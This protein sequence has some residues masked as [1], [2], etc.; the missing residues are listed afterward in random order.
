VE[1]PDVPTALL[2]LTETLV[3]LAVPAGAQIEWSAAHGCSDELALD[4][5]WANGWTLPLIDR[6]AP[7]G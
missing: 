1:S 4:F 3:V 5:E 2:R 6:E 7:P